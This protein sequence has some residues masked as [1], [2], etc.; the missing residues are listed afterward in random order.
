MGLFSTA[1]SRSHLLSMSDV[2]CSVSWC[3]NKCNLP[4]PVPYH[5]FLFSVQWTGLV[6]AHY[7]ASECF[8][9]VSHS[10]VVGETPVPSTCHWSSLNQYLGSSCCPFLLVIA[11]KLLSL[12]LT[13]HSKL[14]LILIPIWTSS[15]ASILSF[16][17][18]YESCLYS[19]FYSGIQGL[20][21]RTAVFLSMVN[22]K[23]K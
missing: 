6:P 22:T 16:V 19:V 18:V 11:M 21:D 10:H 17:C 7:L 3:P 23:K 13:G 9:S 8:R 4:D 2:T 5:L 1:M 14:C 12:S 20:R 15:P